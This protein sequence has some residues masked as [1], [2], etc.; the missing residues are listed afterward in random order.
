MEGGIKQLAEFLFTSDTP[1]PPR[2]IRLQLEETAV[3]GDSTPAYRNRVVSDML[4]T[5]L[6][7]GVRIKHGEDT[8]PSRL[9]KEQLK[10]LGQYI[11]S[12]GYTVQVRSAPLDEPPPVGDGP[13]TELQ[14]YCERFY[15]FAEGVWQE[16]FFEKLD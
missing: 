14:D 15:N 6:M 12:C 1:K 13:A 5:L 7:E 3:P 9:S 8:N 4:M 11:Q 2:S 10:H 16:I